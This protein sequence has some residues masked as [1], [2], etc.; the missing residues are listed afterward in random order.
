MIC[1]VPEATRSRRHQFLLLRKTLIWKKVLLIKKGPVSV[2]T[3]L[4]EVEENYTSKPEWKVI[5]EGG[6]LSV[7]AKLSFRIRKER[8]Q[9]T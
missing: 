7:T 9:K 8:Q 4:K 2:E 1:D 3:S 5:E 6:V